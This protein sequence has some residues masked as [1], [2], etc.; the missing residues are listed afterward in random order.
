MNCVTGLALRFWSTKRYVPSEQCGWQLSVV[1]S[2]P[3]SAEI[4][5]ENGVTQESGTNPRAP[6]R[7]GLLFHG[8]GEIGKREALGFEFVPRD[9]ACE[10]DRLET[11]AAGAIDVFEGQAED[12]ANL[13]V[14][15]ALDDGGDEDDLEA[16]VADVLDAT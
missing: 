5:F 15:E 7:C 3:R 1:V 8:V 13:V 16:G 9:A 4:N 2:S 14:V 6:W 10:A 12:V 11:D